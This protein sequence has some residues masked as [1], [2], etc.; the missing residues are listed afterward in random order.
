MR[1]K[2]HS[3]FVFR[4]YPNR[5]QA[6]LIK[7]TIGCTRLVYNLMLQ[8][9]QAHYQTTWESCRPTPALYKKTFPF[10]KEVDS[11]A[12]VNAQVN[13]EQA[14]KNFFTIQKA[15]YPKYKSKHR[16]KQSYTSN[17]VN[18]NIR[19]ENNGRRIKLPKVGSVRV[20]QHKMI[21]DDWVIKK[22][23]VEYTP[24]GKYIIT[25]LFEYDNQVPDPVPPVN[26][27][28]LD[29]SSG[30]FVITSDG[31]HGDYPKYYRA[32]EEQ[33][34]HEQRKLSHMEPGSKNYAKQKQR[35]GRLYEKTKNQRADWQHKLANRLARDYDAVAVEDLN[36]RAMSQSLNLGKSTMDNA[37]GLFRE[38]LKYK[39]ERKGKQLIVIDK[40]FP[41][42]Q[43][44]S[45]CGYKNTDVKDLDVREWVCPSCGVY[46]DRDKNAAVNIRKKASRLTTA[47]QD[48]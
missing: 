19:F 10:L 34:K 22:A 2:Q 37:F 6:M 23:T 14:Y 12:L 47:Q 30:E 1:V 32:A 42:S 43:L 17:R 18:N 28:G 26:I 9:R 41:S 40:W 3:A 20:R 45:D 36:M 4:A 5:E 27:I 48:T 8:T 46:H 38:K 11:T 39:L 35:V 33:L 24:S 15:G 31:E 21:P 29:Y 16:S 25:V 7:K 13:L 44:C